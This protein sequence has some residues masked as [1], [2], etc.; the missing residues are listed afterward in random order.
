[1]KEIIN[2]T[3]KKSQIHGHVFKLSR[4]KQL[5]QDIAQYRTLINS[6]L[7]GGGRGERSRGG[8][9]KGGGC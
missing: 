4:S 9:Y 5:F 1:M 3:K 2:L 7:R 8:G 6:G